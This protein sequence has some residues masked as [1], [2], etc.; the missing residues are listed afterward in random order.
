MHYSEGQVG[1]IF[2]LRI[3]DG[4]DLLQSIERF[5][6]EKNVQSGMML[7][8]GALKDGR[9]VM[10]PEQAVIPP[11]PH[12]E[13]YESAWE[14]FG[15]ATVYPSSSG[16]K[17]HMHTSMGRGREGLVGCIR[18]KAR[19]YL[20]IEAVLF[21]ISGLNVRRELDQDMGFYMPLLD[22]TL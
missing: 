8:L 6:N 22:H 7:F 3:D 17:I 2:V 13:H 1:R 16:P 11:V 12:F 19:V 15:M 21:E 4:E 5:V 18:D 14:V 9:A 20:V 10:G